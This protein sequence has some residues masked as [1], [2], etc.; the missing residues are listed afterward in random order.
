MPAHK[1]EPLS[2]RIKTVRISIKHNASRLA[3]MA[4]RLNGAPAGGHSATTVRAA[5][6]VRIAPGDNKVSARIAVV[7]QAT[8]REA[9]LPVPSLEPSLVLVEAVTAA[10]SVRIEAQSFQ[11]E[12]THFYAFHATSKPTVH[13]SELAAALARSSNTMLVS[14]RVLSCQPVFRTTRGSKDL[15]LPRRRR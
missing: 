12:E 7:M 14:S 4:D 9:R 3:D 15:H 8:V 10:D 1:T 13:W 2:I 11:A 6:L 5:T